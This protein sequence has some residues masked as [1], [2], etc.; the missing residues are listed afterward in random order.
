[1]GIRPEI[2]DD[3][4]P[5]L[6]LADGQPHSLR[7][8]LAGHGTLAMR[9]ATV[10]ALAAGVGTAELVAA[11]GSSTPTTAATTR[12][13]AATEEIVATTASLSP[14]AVR[15]ARAHHLAP[16]FGGRCARA[17]AQGGQV[18]RDVQAVQEVQDVPVEVQA[19]R[20]PPG[21]ASRSPPGGPSRAPRDGPSRAPR[22]G[23]SR[24]RVPRPRPRPR[25]RA[26]RP[27]RRRPPP[28]PPRRRAPPR[29]R[30]RPRLLRPPRP[31]PRRH[32][33]R[34]TSRTRHRTRP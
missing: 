34:R 31:P 6:S 19:S 12:P 1:M 30:P 4:P 26:H 2:K 17:R 5:E 7:A 32:Q 20:A 29:R 23:P 10:L 25:P 14:A 27:P 22:D 9:A 11:C 8:R 13:A 21:G 3:P 15:N 28:S 18:R 16:S 24:E 33:A